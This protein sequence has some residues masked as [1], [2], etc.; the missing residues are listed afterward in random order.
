MNGEGARF[1]VPPAAF[2]RYRVRQQLGAGTTGPVFHG[3]DTDTRTPVVIKLFTVE[4]SPDRAADAASR[5]AALASELPEHSVLPKVLAGGL[6]ENR[7]TLVSEFA[8]G[9]ALDAALREFGPAAIDDLIPRLHALGAGLDRAHKAGLVHGALHPTDVIV[10][11]ESTHIL[12]VGVAGALAAAGVAFPNRKPY[13]APELAKGVPTRA[14]DQFALAAIAYEW[15]FGKPI[16]RAA[17]RPIEVRSMPEVDRDLLS[18]AFTRALSPAP[19]ERFSSCAEFCHA[20]TRSASTQAQLAGAVEDLDSFAPE[21]AP[22]PVAVSPAVPPPPVSIEPAPEP[23]V[24]LSIRPAAAQEDRYASV[25]PEEPVVEPALSSWNP[26]ATAA[27]DKPPARLGGGSGVGAVEDLE[28]FAPEEAPPPIAVSPD[29]PPPPVSIEPT[30]EPPPEPPVALPIRPVAAPEGRYASA[31]PEEPVVEPALSSWNPSAT[32]TPAKAPA[33]FGGGALVLTLMVGLAGGFAAGYMAKPRAL[34]TA[35]DAQRGQGAQSAEV[36]PA[37]QGAQGAPSTP[38]APSAPAGPDQITA[39]DLPPSPKPAA[40]APEKSS[41]PSQDAA[42]LGG[43]L[44]VR[45]TPA[46]ATVEIDGV[47]RG[48]TPLTLRDLELGTRN[49]SIALKGHIAEER[50]VTLTQARPSRSL[51]VRLSSAAPAPAPP[52]APPRPGASTSPRP[53]TPA[54]FGRPGS[55]ET[56]ALTVE[57]RPAG[58]TV[59]INGRA[60]GVTPLTVDA[61][62]PGAYQVNILMAGYQ[63]F[64]TTVRVVAGERARAAASLSVQEQ[65]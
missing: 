26:S 10:T 21:E 32:A 38:S 61:L 41:A 2:G 19:A 23:P 18:K 15:L 12:G 27:R 57:S 55:A 62:A 5:L 46:G 13:S 16:A 20:V 58:A 56:G 44:L 7:L 36:A 37:A 3:E 28:P 9:Q 8:D 45:S 48:V 31:E 52:P 39:R 43:R 34:Q 47:T 53:S 30:P 59:T 25:E 64:V 24:A 11:P 35:E 65:E 33:R 51:E 6:D 22:P 14:S 4:L 54:T 49:I 40:S 1:D 50:L 63:P 60:S 29:V 42:N 17:D